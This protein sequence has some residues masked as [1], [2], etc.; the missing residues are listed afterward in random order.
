MRHPLGHGGSHPIGLCGTDPTLGRLFWNFFLTRRLRPGG[1]GETVGESGPGGALAAQGLGAGWLVFVESRFH[2]YAFE[3]IAL[4]MYRATE[5][6]TQ[7]TPRKIFCP[8]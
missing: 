8:L 1:G 7:V 6:V 5:P 3:S 2:S 4:T